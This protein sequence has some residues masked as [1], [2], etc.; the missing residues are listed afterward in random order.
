[1]FVSY[2]K[3]LYSTPKVL[4]RRSLHVR[5]KVHFQFYKQIFTKNI[6]ICYWKKTVIDVF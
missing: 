5:N 1:M 6:S 4:N 3:K 2:F